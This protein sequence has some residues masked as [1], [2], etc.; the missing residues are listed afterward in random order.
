MNTRIHGISA[1]AIFAIGFAWQGACLGSSEP[2]TVPAVVEGN[3]KFAFELYGKLRAGEGNRFVSPYSLSSALAMTYAGARG[4]TAKEMASTLH[5]PK[6][7]NQLHQGFR[8]LI[9]SIRGETP[10]GIASRPRSYQL[11]TANALW[12]QQGRPIVPSFLQLTRT[13]YG[14]GLYGV[15][16]VGNPASAVSTI[17]TWVEKQTQGKIRDLLNASSVKPA[18]ALVL[19][20]AIYFKGDWQHVFREFATEKDAVFQT[21]DGRKVNTPLMHQR[22]H[23]R[24]VED[25]SMQ[26]LELPYKS[27]ELSML[28]LLPKQV[29]GL[30]RLEETLSV[31]KLA[32][33]VKGL[34]PTDVAVALPKFTLT[35]TVELSKTLSALGM[36]QAFS[37]QADFSGICPELYLSA[38]IQKAFV[39]VNEKGTE[40]AAATAVVAPAAAIAGREPEPVV[41]RADHP[42]VFMIR[43]NRTGSVLFLGRLVEPK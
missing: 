34:K 22:E 21:L 2:A 38:V 41:F 37:S 5:F 11:S 39:E 8:S 28:V 29:D 20:N 27:A 23:Y 15:D 4:E 1:V 35:E 36:S 16:F 14:A 40:A 30:S 18:P 42:F 24:Y 10:A 6:D 7:S 9:A 33:L 3:N 19:T 43:D 13:H 25:E 32:E 12:C 31:D 26:A 17:N